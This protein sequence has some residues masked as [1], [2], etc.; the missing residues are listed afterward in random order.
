VKKYLTAGA[1]AIAIAAVLFII[2][3]AGRPVMPSYQKVRAGYTISE[4]RLYDRNGILIHEIRMD[5]KVRKLDWVELGSVSEAMK[6]TVILTEDRR[7]YSHS[8]IDWLA[9]AGSALKGGSRGASTIS[10]QAAS[11]INPEKGK[12]GLRRGLTQKLRQMRAAVSL[13]RSWTKDQILEA[14]LN[15]AGFRGELN[16]IGAASV[17]IFQKDPSGINFNEA[18]V[19]CAMLPGN[20]SAPG[21]IAD[22][23]LRIIKLSGSVVHEDEIR[24]LA[25]Q[26]VSRPYYIRPEIALAPHVAGQLL[27]KGA[28]SSVC[29]L[30]KNIQE[31]ALSSLQNKLNELSGRN[32][33]DGAVIVAD[34][35]TGDILAYV[36]NSGISSSARYVDGIKAKRQAGSTLKPFL[37]GLAIE[38]RI[39][40]AA[41]LLDDSP[42]DIPTEAGI[43]I[44][45]NYSNRYMG[46]V[47]V[48]TALASSLNIPAVRVLEL[49]GKEDF[50]ERLKLSGFSTLNED[51]EYYGYSIALGS[52]D[53]TLLDLTA[54]YMAIA[55]GGLYLPLKLMPGK[56]SV[57]TRRIMD[58]RASY[59]ITDILSDRQAR[60]PT[61]ALENVLATRFFSAVKTGTSKDMRDN[62]CIG[63]TKKYTVGVW[64]GNFSGE[65]MWNVSGMSGAAPVWLD[66]MNYL[67]SLDDKP[68]NKKPDGLKEKDISYQRHVEPDRKEVFIEGTEPLGTISAAYK[69]T[70]PAIAYPTDGAVLAIDPDIPE[71]CQ[72]VLFKAEPKSAY[73]WKLN[74]RILGEGS[75]L[76]WKPEK[77]QYRLALIDDNMVEIQSIRFVVR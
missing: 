18:A 24:E 55:N 65:P 71:K 77:G 46:E 22:R 48:R 50:L 52:A 73:K 17:G 57:Q 60:S 4:A 27:K 67:H 36:G 42:H 41:S 43:Y 68:E 10:M 62:W 15:L 56:P 9:V 31:F 23:A 49:A 6:N 21:T 8:G 37:Y 38:K 7:F 13:E 61:F 32:V 1:A 33:K 5:E 20:S 58:D 54:A 44:P 35:Q 53:V 30:S 72:K 69:Y 70:K 63:F 59:I 64:V 29:S 12:K 14:Y 39:I 34:N 51:A 11:F 40:T 66:V 19:L 28:T 45:E 47:S 16:G 3:L 26:A 76:L 25:F 2:F 74:G 75:C